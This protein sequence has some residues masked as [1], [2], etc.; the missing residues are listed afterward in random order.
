MTVLGEL[1]EKLS[2]ALNIRLIHGA[3]LRHGRWY[4]LPYGGV[5]EY[6]VP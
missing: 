6:E 1:L 4:P 3:S 5:N 2:D